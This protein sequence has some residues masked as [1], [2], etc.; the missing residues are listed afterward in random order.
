MNRQEFKKLLK[1]IW[2]FIWESNSAW[3]WIV[4]IILAFVIIKF[5]VYPAL[6]FILST[7]YP[8][9]AVVS[10]SMEHDGSFDDWWESEAFCINTN[11]NQALYYRNFNITKEEFHDFNFRNGFNKGDIMILYGSEPENIEV[12]DIIVFQSIRPDPII[13]R[14]IKRE[15]INST[16]YFQTK[17]DH[18]PSSY[19][20]LK[21]EKIHQ[22]RILGKAV[23]RVPFL[24]WIKITAVKFFNIIRPR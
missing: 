18:N 20:S 9:V 2:W 4:N 14:V 3:S 6:G 12:G 21:E 23:A 24:G 5:L 8:V 16:F 17:G 13:H 10:G 19:P 11:C 7:S 15:K 1:K 22:N